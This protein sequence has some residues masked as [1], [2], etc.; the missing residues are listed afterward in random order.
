MPEELTE[1][2]AAEKTAKLLHDLTEKIE[3]HT[4]GLERV[5]GEKA[6]AAD[7]VKTAEFKAQMQAIKDELGEVSK[8]VARQKVSM[9]EQKAGH[10]ADDPAVIAYFKGIRQMGM[11]NGTNSIVRQ[12]FQFSED[13]QKAF[14]STL[15]G[16]EQKAYA[17]T[18]Y[19]QAGV[20]TLPPERIAALIDIAAQELQTAE[21]YITTV[22]TSSM[23]IQIPKVTAH[24]TVSWA[25]EMVET[26]DTTP[27]AFDMIKIPMHMARSVTKVSHQLLEDP[28]FNFQGWLMGDIGKGFQI[29]FGTAIV[30]GTGIGMPL[31]FMVAPV[32]T[33]KQLEASTITNA[34]GLIKM[35]RALK[36]TYLTSNTAYYMQ[37]PTLADIEVLKS[38]TGSYLLQPLPMSTEFVLKGFPVRFLDDLPAVGAGAYPVVFGDLK[39]AYWGAR[40]NNDYQLIVDNMTLAASG[41]TRFIMLRY[42]GGGQVNQEA[43]RVLEIVAS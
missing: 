16:Q 28:G 31:G 33:V 40:K 11:K 36:A 30:N 6:D 23:E 35:Q 3:Q 1:K 21:T 15:P 17:T 10:G 41:M 8:S 12:Q 43:Y 22:Q 14:S 38:T 39:Q 9:Q 34:D 2:E 32:T 37:R 27:A 26:S 24:S 19:T 20:L 4:K 25:Q 18:S 29:K 5:S 42:F 13:E 7:V